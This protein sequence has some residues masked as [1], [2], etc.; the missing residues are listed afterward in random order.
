MNQQSKIS[1][2]R[3]SPSNS[4]KVRTTDLSP[5]NDIRFIPGS[6]DHAEGARLQP[7]QSEL[8][9]L[10][11]ATHHPAQDSARSYADHHQLKVTQ[12]MTLVRPSLQRKQHQLLQDLQSRNDNMLIGSQ[13]K[14]MLEQR[15]IEIQRSSIRSLQESN[16]LSRAKFEGEIRGETMVPDHE[17]AAKQSVVF[18][19]RENQY[20][21][22][23]S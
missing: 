8:N 15:V 16:V 21:T 7:S 11:A 18:S 2:E 4:A 20:G 23:I 3:N 5:W 1:T 10:A 22:Q 9:V 19:R 6:S 13:K 17:A 14:K 12:A